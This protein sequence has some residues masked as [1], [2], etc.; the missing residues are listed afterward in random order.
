MKINDL[1]RYGSKG[2]LSLMLAAQIAAI[3]SIAD[4][5]ADKA[6]RAGT[7][8]K[9]SARS[10]KNEAKEAG[11]DLTGQGSTWE[12]V[13]DD[14]KDGARDAKDEANYQKRKAERKAR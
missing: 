5:A 3:P 14:V 6:D 9:K 13:K 2:F 4:T 7:D 1:T 11:R 10:L 8:V 12:N